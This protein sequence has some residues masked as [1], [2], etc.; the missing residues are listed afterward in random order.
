M[1][2]LLIGVIGQLEDGTGHCGLQLQPL[3][4]GSC[5]EF[6]EA[7]PGRVISWM[8]PPEFVVVIE[9]PGMEQELERNCD[10]LG[11]GL[12]CVSSGGVVYRIFDQ[13]DKVFE[14][15]IAVVGTPESRVVVL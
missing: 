10:D 15:L 11:R 1:I 12:G 5:K 4:V 14:R 8:A 2:G 13:I 9:E 3:L 6:L 7:C